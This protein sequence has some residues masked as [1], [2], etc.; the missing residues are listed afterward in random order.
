MSASFLALILLSSP[1]S[2]FT[3]TPQFTAQDNARIAQ[4]VEDVN[5]A[6]LTDCFREA[7][8]GAE[9]SEAAPYTNA[10]IWSL[11]KEGEL[12]LQFALYTPKKLKWSRVNAYTE[13]YSPVIYFNRFYFKRATPAE[14]ANT[15]AH[16]M[17]HSLG[18]THNDKR[19]WGSSVPYSLGRYTEACLTGAR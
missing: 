13:L 3:T 6:T 16:E 1:V 14:L 18:F 15:T 5:A 12:D 9:F 17:T 19:L 10:G 2:S 7:V 4:A 11:F 8:I